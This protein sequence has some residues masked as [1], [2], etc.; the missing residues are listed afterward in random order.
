MGAAMRLHR[1]TA[2]QRSLLGGHQPQ[3][4]KGTVHSARSHSA[5]QADLANLANSHAS[6]SPNSM[7]NFNLRSPSAPLDGTME[8][9]RGPL[10]LPPRTVMVRL[11]YVYSR[12][13]GGASYVHLLLDQVPE[14]PL[15]YSDSVNGSHC[16]Q[17]NTLR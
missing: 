13:L 6:S 10:A 11:F 14:D 1:Q 4:S 16:V 15:L 17:L 12:Y 3:S 5:R 2:R 8:G 7:E 9:S